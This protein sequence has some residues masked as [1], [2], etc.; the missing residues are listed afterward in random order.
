MA[1]A[2]VLDEVARR[3]QVGVEPAEL[4]AEIGRYA[5]ATGR[6]PEDVRTRLEKDGGI[7]RLYMGLRREKA[8]DLLRSRATIVEA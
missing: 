8:V 5:A 3:E 2:I 6:T 7:S 4:E 1:S